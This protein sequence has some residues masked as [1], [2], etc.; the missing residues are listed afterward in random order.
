VVD[1]GS[2]DGTAEAA[3]EAGARVFR[4]NNAGS[5]AAIK[6]G[7]R[8]A[9]GD[10]VVT[11]DGDGEHRAEDILRL[12]RPIR[13]DQADLVLG[14][15]SHITRTS[16]RFLNWLTRLRVREISDT[17]TG[18]R[19]MRRDLAL[20]L[21]LK[22]RCICGISILEP[23]AAGARIAEVPIELIRVVKPRRIAWFHIAQTWY[24]LRWLAT[25]KR[26]IN[27]TKVT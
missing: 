5:I 16:E 2:S 4:Q 25:V 18:F 8:E 14:A 9:S 6:R 13:D 3:T 27:S 19:A 1:D 23:T 15:R 24:V 21:E 7:F 20:T 11:M 12:V 10:I 17:G 22:G 26:E